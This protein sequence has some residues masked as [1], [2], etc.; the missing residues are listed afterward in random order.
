MKFIGIVCK[1]DELG[2]VV[3]FIELCCIFGIVEKDVFEIYVDDEKIIFKK[4]KLNM[5][6]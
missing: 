1:V 6:C 4:Y 5:I 2:C 3:I